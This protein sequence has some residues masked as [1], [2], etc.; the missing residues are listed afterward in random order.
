MIVNLKSQGA[1]PYHPGNAVGHRRRG[2]PVADGRPVHVCGVYYGS[3]KS[4]IEGNQVAR[5]VRR[6]LYGEFAPAPVTWRRMIRG[7]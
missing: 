5:Q 6:E 4:R 3:F 2:D 1:R 7:A